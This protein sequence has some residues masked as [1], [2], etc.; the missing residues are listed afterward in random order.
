MVLMAAPASDAAPACRAAWL[1][2]TAQDTGAGD[3]R[4]QGMELRLRNAGPASC[5]VSPLPDV[6]VLDA[7][8]RR[9]DV[10]RTVPGTRFMHPGPVVP[11]L[12]LAPNAAVRASLHWDRVPRHVSDA[13]HPLSSVGVSTAQGTVSAAVSGV[14]CGPGSG[15]ADLA[16]TRFEPVSTQPD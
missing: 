8:G 2:L 15:P 3:A 4:R 9:L 10:A 1:V 12:T 13:C 16:V 6:A 11:P 7:Q 14:L 5:L